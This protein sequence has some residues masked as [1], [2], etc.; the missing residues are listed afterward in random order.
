LDA[1]FLCSV[2]F[3]N[4]A[5]HAAAKAGAKIEDFRARG[6]FL[7]FTASCRKMNNEE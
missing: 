4:G 6:F 3:G 2:F 7:T 1:H 5:G